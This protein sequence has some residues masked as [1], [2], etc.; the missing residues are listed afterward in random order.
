MEHTE[1]AAHVVGLDHDRAYDL[2]DEIEERLDERWGIDLEHF[3]AI[4]SALIRYTPTLPAPLTGQDMHIFG[5][6][7]DSHFL[8][9][10]RFPQG[11]GPVRKA[12]T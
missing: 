12:P 10:S 5:I 8:A 7:R 11:G 2:V 4:A 6:H 9:L 1:L 3:S